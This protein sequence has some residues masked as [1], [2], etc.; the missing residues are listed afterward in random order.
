[1]TSV[2]TIAPNT[3]YHIA[4]T[5]TDDLVT[6]FVN[7]KSEASDG[8]PQR[9]PDYD[10][11]LLLGAYEP[12]RPS[13]RGWLDEIAFYNRGLTAAEIESLYRTRASGTCAPK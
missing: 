9:F 13:L 8:P 12:G 4:V 1:M 11:P 3:W 10:A 2:S 6:L 7:G 5:K